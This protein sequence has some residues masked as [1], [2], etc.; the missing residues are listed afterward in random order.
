M[1]TPLEIHF[2]NMERSDFVEAAV[3]EKA[4]KLER[5]FGGITSCHVYIDAPHHHHRKGNHYQVRVE[6]RVPGSDLAVNNK[7][8]NVNAHEDVYVAIRDAF[9]AVERQLKKWKQKI[10]GQIKSHE[11]PLQGRIVE[12]RP[13]EGYGRIATNDGRLIYF[14]KNSVVNEAFPTLNKGV[15]VELVVQEG[16][17][18]AGPQASTVRAIGSLKFVDRAE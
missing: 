11:G 16:E 12:I 15:V 7:P 17:S 5:F 4:A 18:E 6:L 14:H 3:R 1:Q 10:G 8:G 9:N 13:D 2:T